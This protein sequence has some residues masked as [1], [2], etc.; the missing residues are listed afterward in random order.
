MRLSLT[1]CVVLVI[2]G[3]A[4]GFQCDQNATICRT[5][6]EITEKLTMF[7]E[8]EKAVYAKNGSLYR[9]DVTDI[10]LARPVNSGEVIAG[11]GWE[12]QRMVVVAN[13]TL[14]GPPIVAYKG[15]V[16]VIRVKNSLPSDTV[17]VHWYGIEQRG[18]PYMD[19]ASFITQCPINPG[20][21]FT[22]T[23]RVDE[24]GTFWYHSSAGAQRGKGLYGALIVLDREPPANL[25]K[26]DGDFVLQIQDWN[27]DYDAEQGYMLSKDGV[28]ENR[29]QI[30]TTRLPR[31]R[32]NSLWNAHSS[33]INGN[34]R[35]YDPQTGKH[36]E[37]PL[38]DFKVQEGKSYRFRVINAA[39]V[40][41][42]R[43]SVD[44]HNITII[45][46]DGKMVVPVEVES[47]W[48]HPGERFDFLL[49][50]TARKGKYL[51]RGVAEDAINPIPAEAVL[52][53]FGAR[54]DVDINS[55]RSQCNET[56]PCT[57]LN[58]PFQFYRNNPKLRCLAIEELV[59]DVSNVIPEYQESH[60]QEFF[61]NFAIPG[62]ETYPAT[63]NNVQ[64]LQP[65]VSALSQPNEIVKPC[66]KSGCKGNETCTCT[67]ILD[68]IHNNTVQFVFMNMGKRQT[69]H[70]ISMHG[71]SF[72]VL[73]MGFANYNETTGEYISQNEDIKCEG[74]ATE[75]E[76]F[77][78]K[79]SWTN[80]EWRNGNVSGLNLV[81][82]PQK[83]TVV[84]PYGGYV[85]LRFK[86]DNPGFWMIKSNSLP[87]SLNGMTVLMNESF[88]YLPDV[89]KNFPTCRNFEGID[90]GK[91][92]QTV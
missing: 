2:L 54:P 80:P 71:H 55:E 18:T 11:D 75:D 12:K 16:L 79:P 85:V 31:G 15:Q 56:E 46:S 45:A 1:S 14:P 6:L 65:T 60:F 63:V 47:F 21:T 41:S 51:I 89:P 24:S 82:P 76:A 53:Y 90:P 9:Y 23:F 58:C 27:H 33:L 36:N 70:T 92:V 73:K 59:S 32:N 74:N 72:Y 81:D 48:V 68:V 83:D 29:S 50:A 77:C 4:I 57:V 64:F 40:Y 86:A 62:A 17:S 28:Y 88:S 20:Q 67:N 13:G 44:G 38:R 26:V 34:G 69:S 39:S 52:H 91:N 87:E 49:E 22:Y 8:T 42:Y 3:G 10:N 30:L 43:V 61:L 19:G 66:S 78:N 37:A 35:Y 25:D 7:H 84:V 5:S